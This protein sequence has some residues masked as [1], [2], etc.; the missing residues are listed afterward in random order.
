M[1]AELSEARTAVAV[2][3]I[4]EDA[5]F[6][7]RTVRALQ[8][9]PPS[10]SPIASM[11]LVPALG[12]ITHETRKWLTQHAPN[13]AAELPT[14]ELDLL[15][16]IRNASKWFD[17]SKEGQDGAIQRFNEL[18]AA[19]ADTFLGNTPY[20]WARRF[21]SDLGLYLHSGTVVLNTHLVG[22]MLGKNALETGPVLRR[23]AATMAGQAASLTTEVPTAA[24]FVDGLK[25]LR[26]R[27][28][29]STKYYR[30]S[31]LA[32]PESGYLHLVWNSLGFLTFMVPAVADDEATVFKLQYIALFHATKTVR[33][34]LPDLVPVHDLTDGDPAR[35]LRNDLIHYTPHHGYPAAALDARRPRQALVEHTYSLTFAE[36]AARTSAELSAL[37]TRLGKRLGH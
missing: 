20:A 28:V 18:T 35:Q 2:A 24:S 1:P 26:N 27:D 21:E 6:V 16:D 17:A 33:R 29:R 4:L 19:H 11:A 37:H 9:C 22:V 30:Q 34:L 32:L 10:Q 23:M 25:P 13:I 14:D 5:G 15:L 7:V 36:V 3:S 31:G 12:I 8:R